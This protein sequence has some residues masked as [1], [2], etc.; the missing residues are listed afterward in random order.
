MLEP[1]DKDFTTTM[2]KIKKDIVGKINNIHQQMG[3]F[4]R[5][6]EMLEMKNQ[7]QR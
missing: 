4:I 5:K 1:E 3:H 2:I 6:T 7:Y